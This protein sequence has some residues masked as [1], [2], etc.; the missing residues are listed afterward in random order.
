MFVLD[1]SITLS[2]C[3]P[4]EQNEF[5]DRA[6]QEVFKT[7]VFVPTLWNW[8]VVN[9]L[10]M[11]IKRNRVQSQDLC[12]FELLLSRLPIHICHVD[13]DR[14]FLLTL[15]QREN[16]TAYDTVYLYLAMQKS[17]P[18]AT[19]DKKLQQAARNNGVEI[20]GEKEEVR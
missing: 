6:L 4:D 18:L 3:L 13:I 1:T 5:A 9:G 7:Q 10:Y 17:V 20:F 14:M 19:L 15:C 8:E 12:H 2:W 11:A 16:L